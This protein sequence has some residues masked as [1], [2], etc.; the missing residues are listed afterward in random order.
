[1]TLFLVLSWTSIILLDIMDVKNK[2]K[3]KQGVA[4]CI[5]LGQVP[6]KKVTT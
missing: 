6:L 5:D 3:L 1:M 4:L 2:C